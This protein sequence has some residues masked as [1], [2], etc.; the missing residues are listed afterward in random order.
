M[1]ESGLIHACQLDGKGGARAMDWDDIRRWQPATGPVWIHLDYSVEHARQWLSEQSGLDEVATRALLRE[2]TR[3][4]TSNMGE[5]TLVVLRGVNLNPEADPEDMVSIR[6][7]IDR[8]RIISAGKRS[9]LSVG[10]VMQ[11]LEQGRGPRTTGGLLASFS[12]RITQRMEGPMAELEDRAGQLEEDVF[13]DGID[14]TLRG[15]LSDIRRQ[16]IMLRRYLAPQ[17]EAMRALYGDEH[18]WLSNKDRLRVREA[19]DQLERHVEH[20][21]A[22]RE[23]AMVSQ[24]ELSNRLSERINARLYVMSLVA[25]LFLPLSFFTGL[26]G[27]NV[28]GIPGT[29]NKA[30]FAIVVG[31]LV[32]VVALQ[33]AYFKVRKWF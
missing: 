16:T 17:R 21:D 2:E 4:R 24:E 7:W 22:V 13:E 8:E 23:R 27:I 1:N 20:L 32:V 12:I 10:D 14:K 26:L 18:S 15:E 28:G 11:A 9:L 3:P 29:D 33:L 19:S 5:G 30:A 31:I 6:L 25:A